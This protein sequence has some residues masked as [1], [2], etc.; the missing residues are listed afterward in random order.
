MGKILLSM[1][2]TDHIDA[3]DKEGNTA[4]LIAAKAN[5]SEISKALIQ[6]KASV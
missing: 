5:Q 1:A 3:V 6:A 4:L 2:P